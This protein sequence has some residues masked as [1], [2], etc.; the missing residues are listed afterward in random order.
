[1]KKEERVE[2]VARALIG[3]KPGQR[4]RIIRASDSWLTHLVEGKIVTLESRLPNEKGNP[5]NRW[6][7]VEHIWWLTESSMELL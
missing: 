5:K 2:Q 6:R 7:I 4:I 1:M 3:F